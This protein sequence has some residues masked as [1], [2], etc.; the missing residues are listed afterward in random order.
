MG[1][2][3]G[4]RTEEVAA[5]KDMVTPE[6]QEPAAGMVVLLLMAADRTTPGM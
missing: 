1:I 6:V 3:P 5:N 2:I 4:L